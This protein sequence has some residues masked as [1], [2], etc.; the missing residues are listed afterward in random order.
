MFCC[1]WNEMQDE[2]CQK[3]GEKVQW[4]KNDVSPCAHALLNLFSHVSDDWKSEKIKRGE[5]KSKKKR[6]RNLKKKTFEGMYKNH[7]LKGKKRPALDWWNYSFSLNSKRAIWWS[8]F[9]CVQKSDLKVRGSFQWIRLWADS[10]KRLYRKIRRK[11][12]Y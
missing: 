5:K 1:L 3:W 7:H 6:E 11:K 2:N 8:L 9:L 12:N 4:N 10:N